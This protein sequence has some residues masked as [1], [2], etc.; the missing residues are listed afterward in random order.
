MNKTHILDLDLQYINCC[1]C[2]EDNYDVLYKEKFSN[3]NNLGLASLFSCRTYHQAH[4]RIIRCK[5]CGLVY[6]NPTIPREEILN[7]YSDSLVGGFLEEKDNLELSAHRYLKRIEKYISPGR[8]LDIGCSA[9]FLIDSARKRG[10]DV[11]GVEPCKLAADFG[12]SEL[13]LNILNKSYS[14]DDFPPDYFDLIT[15]I[16]VIDHVYSPALFL[17]GIFYNLRKKGAVFI[18]THDIQ[19][20]LARAL[21][22]KF[23]PIDIQHTYFFSRYTLRHLL[24]K[25]GFKILEINQARIT[26]SLRYYLEALK[27]VSPTSYDMINYLVNLFCISGMKITIPSGNIEVLA[28]K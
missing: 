27:F 4:L 14:Q 1:L 18:V 20:Y 24:E 6:S 25:V 10:W 11:Y 3:N 17:Q 21:G 22:E 23:P 16:H 28:I 15:A 9:G 13:A 5:N 19:S 7:A 12:R 2:G 26:Y 8:L